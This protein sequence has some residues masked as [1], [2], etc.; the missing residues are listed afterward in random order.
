MK[1]G[2]ISWVFL[3]ADFKITMCKIF[4]GKSLCKGE[5]VE[6]TGG[7]AEIWRCV[8]AV[9]KGAFQEG[10]LE[11]QSVWFRH[12]RKNILGR[13]MGGSWDIVTCQRRPLWKRPHILQKQA[14]LSILA[15][16]SQPPTESS[17]KKGGFSDRFRTQ[18]L[19]LS[20]STPPTAGDLNGT[21]SWPQLL[22]WLKSLFN[23]LPSLVEIKY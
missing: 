23:L 18:Q 1:G 12:S 10:G 19:V 21:C 9:K 6:G 2:C 11:R 8:T 5:K 22:F 3:E 13:P 20:V 4:T 7:G 16:L 14:C 15:L 17:L